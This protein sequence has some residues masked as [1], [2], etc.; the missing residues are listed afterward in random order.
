MYGLDALFDFFEELERDNMG[1]QIALDV[2]GICC[3]YTQYDSIEEYN[4]AHDE[5]FSDW[6][7]CA[8]NIEQVV[9]PV[10]P[11]PRRPHSAIVQ[12]H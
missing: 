9:I 8:D 3:D 4:E 5:Q 10:R 11:T 2:I 6:E 7:E 12:N 1:E